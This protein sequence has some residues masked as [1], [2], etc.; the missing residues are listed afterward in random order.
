MVAALRDAEGNFPDQSTEPYAD[1]T[2]VQMQNGLLSYLV[3]NNPPSVEW[4]IQ[5]ESTNT[6]DEFQFFFSTLPTS[7]VENT[8]D[9]TL[10][11]M[12]DEEAVAAVE[13]EGGIVGG[14]WGC[15][16]CQVGCAALG[17]VLVALIAAGA[18]YITAGAAPVVA[19]V[20]LLGCTPAAAVALVTGAVAA[21]GASVAICIAYTCS[22]A[23]ACPAPWGGLA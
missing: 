18:T 14:S 17:V 13:A 11:S 19:L 8:M 22:W 3:M 23:H 5:A 21:I 12:A 10:A 7:D 16:W 4:T 15:W 2:V 6:D 20:T 1:T 9:T